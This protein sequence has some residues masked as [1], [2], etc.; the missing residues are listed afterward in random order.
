MLRG[1]KCSGIGQLLLPVITIECSVSGMIRIII[2]GIQML[3]SL[4]MIDTRLK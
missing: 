3:Y 4:P 2:A 1:R